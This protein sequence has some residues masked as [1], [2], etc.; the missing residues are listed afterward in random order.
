MAK[1]QGNGGPK[2]RGG[3]GGGATRTVPKVSA[4]QGGAAGANRRERKEEA[5][6]QREALQRKIE[7][8]R[9]TRMWGTGVVAAAV[10]VALALF[11]TL[12]GGGSSAQAN[13]GGSVKSVNWASLPGV[14]TG[15]DPAQWTANTQDLALRVQDL[16][17]PPL[18]SS[19]SLAFHIHQ[20]LEIYIDGKKVSVPQG[21]G[22]DQASQRLAV[23][24]T[25][26]PDGVIHVESPKVSHIYTL[27]DFF[28]V[29]GLRLTKD[30]IG[31]L[32]AT[33]DASL[34][35]Y[36]NGQPVSGDPALIR[37]Q[38]HQVIVVAY[39]TQQQV[40][41]PVPST[42]DWATSSAGG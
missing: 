24:H 27:G 25:H 22:I 7:R 4:A 40:P 35:A 42:F 17:I 18:S 12:R 5:R 37:L 15:T 32:C 8:R 38:E 23:L 30:C 10:V 21:I 11:F 39:G 6:R 16:G 3:G 29:W 14:M 19:E 2:A 9:R 26:E 20:E 1:R 31:G 33:G 41:N 13:Q 28:G 36:V 34:H